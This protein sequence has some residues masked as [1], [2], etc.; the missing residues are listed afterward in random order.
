[1]K[2]SEITDRVVELVSD[3][4]GE[5]RQLVGGWTNM[6]LDDMAGRGHLRSLEREETA[7]IQSGQREYDLPAETDIVF[8]VF[9]PAWGFPQGLLI[10]CDHD[11]YIQ[12]LLEDG[13]DASGQPKYY[14]LFGY[15][16]LRLHPPAHPDY[17][18]GDPTIYQKLHILKYKDIAHLTEG[19]DITEIKIKHIPIII[20]GAYAM[21]ARFD[22]AL[23]AKD[24]KVEYERGI[25]RIVGD[26][27]A[28]LDMAKVVRYRDL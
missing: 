4:S 10:K 6:V 19:D 7:P 15:K 11:A 20:Y 21:G 16:T 14:N 27:S 23:D 22:S 9:V 3:K 17:A 24:A 2:K 1:M 13:I 12:K 25:L 28:D 18:P 26:Q 8:K 5:M